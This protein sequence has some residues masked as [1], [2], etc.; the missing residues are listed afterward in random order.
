M[1]KLS[2]ITT[3]LL[4]IAGLSVIPGLTAAEDWPLKRE[5]DLSSGFGDFRDGHFH[6][7]VDLRTGGKIGA[8]VYSPVD[9]Y[10]WRVYMSY[11]GYGKG[12][13]IMGDNGYLYVYGHLSQ[14]T[15]KIDR[16]VKEAQMAV[17]RYRQDIYFPKDSIRVKQGEFLAY[18]GQAGKG[19][20]HL[21]FEKRTGD[22]IPINPLTNG[23]E[24]DDKTKPSF[25]RLGIQM[26]DD[27][28]LLPNGR[29]KL[30]VDV[31]PSKGP[32]Q[33]GLDTL[34]Y[35]HRPFGL[36]VDGY[37]QM[38]SGGMRQAI[39]RLR[40]FIDDR[41]MYDTRFDSASYE[42]TDAVR[43]EYDYTEAANGRKRVRRLFK[44]S[45]NSFSGSSGQLGSGI[46]G[47]DGGERVGRHRARIVG[48]DSFGNRSEVKFDFLW[49]PRDYIYQMDSVIMPQ[50]LRTEYYFTPV[51]GF[52]EFGIDSVVALRN[53]PGWWGQ[54]KEVQVIPLENGRIICR[55]E[56]DRTPTALLALHL[57][58][59]NTI[60]RDNIFNGL[61]E[62]QA[63][64]VKPSWEV[65]DDGLLVTLD[66]KNKKASESRIELYYGDS[67]LGVEYPQYFDLSRHICFVPPRPEYER[68]DRIGAAMTRDSSHR[69]RAF[70]D[71][72]NIHRVGG[73]DLQIVSVDDLLEL[74]FNR[75]NL[76]EPRFIELKR[77]YSRH[78]SA[79]HLNSAHYQ[80]LPEA[81]VT[82]EDFLMKLR[83]PGRK[84]NDNPSG[85]CWLDKEEDRWVWLDNELA[86]DSLMATSLGGG[87]FAAVFDYDPPKILHLSVNEGRTY[88]TL[89]PR[90][91]FLAVDSLSGIGD[92]E[93]ISVKIDTKWQI[94]DFD[95]ETARCETQLVEPLA[96]GPHH[97]AIIIYDRAGNMTEQYL[98]FTV[99]SKQKRRKQTGR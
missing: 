23:F 1:L 25:S 10:V 91:A 73:R 84:L 55:I 77:N 11:S 51:D 37:D 57:Y 63:D 6:G 19:G 69:M 86:G 92:D 74:T 21:H 80:V 50:K 82:R 87:S 31:K 95:P 36:L 96:P 65:V 99:K 81:F 9:G 97:L 28:S 93:D 59:A 53:I 43:L 14:M 75:A 27:H 88:N 15:G 94:V 38:R 35:L 2:S 68:I 29:R 79:L 47:A 78:K 22:N 67:L 83:I 71:S 12:L 4:L 26:T 46:F 72:A 48:D 13:Y 70:S 32:G 98:N 41:L 3:S 52:D 90:I 33:F 5:T 18:T 42:T 85:I 66:I 56:S 40:L 61:H 39:Y 62:Q 60:I 76:Y 20:P 34:I 30:F 16:P 17:Q 64:R 49:G 89:K 58:C 24:L 44:I 8:E 45:G 7:G 54:S